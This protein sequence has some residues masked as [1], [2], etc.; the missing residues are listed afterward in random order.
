MA[1]PVGSAFVKLIFRMDED[2]FKLVSEGAA[3]RQRTL[4]AEIR[5]LIF[6]AWGVDYAG[7]PRPAPPRAKVAGGSRVH[8]KPGAVVVK[9]CFLPEQH[10][11]I[12]AEAAIS[13]QSFSDRASSLIERGLERRAAVLIPS[14]A[15]RA[16]LAEDYLDFCQVYGEEEAARRCRVLKREAAIAA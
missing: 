16:G 14:W 7:E 5:H 11:R 6:E 3:A 2:T 10:D 12:R 9:G 4:A 13:G 15:D 8:C 1:R